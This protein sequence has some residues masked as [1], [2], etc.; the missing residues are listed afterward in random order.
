MREALPVL[1]LL[2]MDEDSA[3]RNACSEIAQK[4]GFAV[5]VAESPDAA[6]EV[7]KH[8]RADLM[9]LNLQ[10]S[11]EGGLSLL[12]EVKGLNP[13][14]KVI[15][16]TAFA[17]IASAVKAMRVGASDYLMK[18]FASEELTTTLERAGE[19][20]RFD[21][22]SR[23]LRERLRDD[24]R[25]GPLMG[26]SPE[27]EKLYR[28]LSKVA[29]S[30]HPVLILGESGTGRESIARSIHFNGPN[31]Q[32]RF[33]PVDC[34]SLVPGL[35]ESEL[36]GYAKGAIAGVNKAKDGLLT[37]AEGATV[38]LDE[39]GDLSLPLQAKLLRALQEK[40]VEPV[41][42][43]HAV[44]VTARL[45]AASSRDLLKMVEQG[46]FRRDLYFR[47]NIVNLSIP[48]LRRRKE[49][50]PALVQHFLVQ[51][52]RESGRV[53]TFSDD[54]LRTLM[55]YDW[56]GN[57]RE[58]EDA[59]ER[60][61]ALSSGP[62]LHIGD[63]PTQMQHLRPNGRGEKTELT[64]EPGRE[65][66]QGETIEE[67]IVPLADLERQAILGTIRQLGGD[68]VMAAKLL[69]IGKTTLYRKLKEYGILDEMDSV[70][71]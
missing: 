33:V 21:L 20:R 40:V 35:M 48:P 66:G 67:K 56:P 18:P 1:H 16:M 10:L 26:N 22:E 23:R 15:V 5:E 59:I 38:F 61:C 52:Q 71:K 9:L 55:E 28:I 6:R 13:E 37:A 3:V 29:H 12:E 57:V 27:M 65:H 51:I 36:F 49:D 68:K 19:Q 39:V 11:G 69:G 41:G 44:A 70:A 8:G 63:M 42:S 31:A 4:M 47:L 46:K 50:I 24:K 53:H 14:T 45:L 34:G 7:L 2:V 64:T 32:H 62:L 25:V 30:N 17:T 60:A 58:L 54:A 43:T